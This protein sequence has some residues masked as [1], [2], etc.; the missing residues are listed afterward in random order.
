MEQATGLN[1]GRLPV[2][3][4]KIALCEFEANLLRALSNLQKTTPEEYARFATLSALEAD[5]D[6]SI[7]PELQRIIKIAEKKS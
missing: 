1:G 3:E 6:E 2:Y 5:L 7:K 4:I